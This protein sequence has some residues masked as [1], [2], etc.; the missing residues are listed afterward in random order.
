MTKRE[1]NEDKEVVMVA[2]H[3]NGEA[4]Q[5]ASDELKA[6]KEVVITAVK[7]SGDALY[8]AS[9][10]LKADKEVVIAANPLWA[11]LQHAS[12]ELKADKELV[13]TAIKN[14]SGALQYASDELKADKEVVMAGVKSSGGALQ[15][16][17]D[18]LK[19]DKEV[20]MTAVKNYGG[21]LQHASDEL[22]ADKEVVMAGGEKA[23][24]YA[25]NGQNNTLVIEINGRGG[26][27][28]YHRLPIDEYKELKDTSFKWMTE[29]Y[30]DEALSED[31][32]FMWDISMAEVTI[33]LN[34]KTLISEQEL[35]KLAKTKIE[36]SQKFWRDFAVADLG[37]ENYYV[38]MVWFH[39]SMLTSRY[40]W[41]NV[42]EWDPSKL[43][44]NASESSLGDEKDAQCYGSF[45]V[46]YNGKN[47]DESDFESSP[48][49]GYYGPYYFP[50]TKK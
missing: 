41:L 23:L 20:V 43:T 35:P 32:E 5:H 14:D 44:I 6:D 33:T 24:E 13:L 45:T 37:D 30:G 18:E 47:P 25:L 28:G 16:A 36:D 8:Y 50:P 11:A 9:D 27:F 39:D 2:V 1:I 3:E 17:S 38:G 26:G 21:A 49:T 48:K 19:A 15:H 42:E 31:I 7:S 10:E 12:D 4:L 40:E 46:D 22:K 29:E 34:G